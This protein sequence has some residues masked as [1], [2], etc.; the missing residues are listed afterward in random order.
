[1]LSGALSVSGDT[2]GA[3]WRVPGTLR[4]RFFLSLDV[5]MDS[6]VFICLLACF[7]LSFEQNQIQGLYF[8]LPEFL[9]TKD[10]T[11]AVYVS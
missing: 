7:L 8:I 2:E 1:M 11:Q 9:Q 4:R 5:I 10:F 6:V 3:F